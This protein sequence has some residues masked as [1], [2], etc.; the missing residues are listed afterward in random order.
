MHKY[1]YRQQLLP[2]EDYLATI[3]K[4]VRDSDEKSRNNNN[5]GECFPHSRTPLIVEPRRDQTVIHFHTQFIS[6]I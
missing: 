5:T 4:V 6:I 3:R 2:T 1:R